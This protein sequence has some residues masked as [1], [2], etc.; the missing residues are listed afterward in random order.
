MVAHGIVWTLKLP[1]PPDGLNVDVTADA[2]R[3]G[4]GGRVVLGSIGDHTTRYVS[5]GSSNPFSS[6]APTGSNTTMLRDRANVRTK[7]VTRISPPSAFAHNRAA[8]TTGSPS[9]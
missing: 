7:A 1:I 6:S 4:N 3:A 9:C 5:T 2:S 8:S